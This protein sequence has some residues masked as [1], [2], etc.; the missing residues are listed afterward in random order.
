MDIKDRCHMRFSWRHRSTQ[1]LCDET[2]T[3][4]DNIFEEAFMYDGIEDYLYDVFKDPFLRDCKCI[5]RIDE[6]VGALSLGKK[7]LYLWFALVEI[8]NPK[9]K[10]ATKCLFMSPNT[11]TS[12][13]IL[14]IC[15]RFKTNVESSD[16]TED[17][18]PITIDG[19]GIVKQFCIDMTDLFKKYELDE[20]FDEN[21]ENETKGISNE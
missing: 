9:E 11:G 21:L 2:L 12:K 10:K 20:I 4:V 15:M 14:E 17:F 7:R 6:Y 8:K 3:W 5:C 16:A 1:E 13:K 19:D 18:M